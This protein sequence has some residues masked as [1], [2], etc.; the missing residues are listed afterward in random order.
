MA[1][2]PSEPRRIRAPRLQKVEGSV[3]ADGAA[4]WLRL[5]DEDGLHFDVQLNP[6]ILRQTI[7]F[8]IARAQE[9]AAIRPASDP[10]EK[11]NAIAVERMLSGPGRAPGET[12]LTFLAGPLVL[13]M[14]VQ[15]ADI[16]EA[17]SHLHGSSA[18]APPGRL[19]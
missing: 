16:L 4:I 5:T 15:D 8:M 9:A 18:P 2:P 12:H 3:V 19:Q 11:V 7:A 6:T 10:P 17:A 13:T 1:K 14:A